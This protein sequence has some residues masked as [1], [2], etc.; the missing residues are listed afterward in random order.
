MIL[1]KYRILFRWPYTAQVLVDSYWIAQMNSI[2]A[3]VPTTQL[4][5]LQKIELGGNLSSKQWLQWEHDVSMLT[6]KIRTRLLRPPPLWQHTSPWAPARTHEFSTQLPDCVY[7][8]FSVHRRHAD[9][10]WKCPPTFQDPNPA[11]NSCTKD[12]DETDPGY[13]DKWWGLS[14]IYLEL[15][16]EL[17]IPTLVL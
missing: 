12:L 17:I 4:D 11:E 3:P 2:G 1:L 16:K 7:M 10:G 13:T 5:K 14:N 9:P 15:S 8:L 6:V